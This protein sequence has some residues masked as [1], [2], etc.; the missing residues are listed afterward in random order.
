MLK[1]WHLN[2]GSIFSTSLR[3]LLVSN[4]ETPDEANATRSRLALDVRNR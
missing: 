1:N 3:T 4:P 2:G